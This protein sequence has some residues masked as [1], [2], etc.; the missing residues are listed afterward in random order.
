MYRNI[1]FLAVLY[2]LLFLVN[3]L[4]TGASIPSTVTNNSFK[5]VI[6]GTNN[7]PVEGAVVMNNNGIILAT[8]SNDG[9]FS[10]DLTDQS[11]ILI[12]AEGYNNKTVYPQEL[13]NP[14][15]E[16]SA[17][18]AS[19]KGR[20][21]LAFGS[22]TQNQ[23]VGAV[24]V[25]DA[26]EMLSLDNGQSVTDAIRGRVAGMY[27]SSNLRNYDGMVYLIDGLERDPS[28]LTIN[29]VD[30]I[31]VLKDAP[32]RML[33]GVKGSNGVVL[34]TTKR[35][36]AGKRLINVNAEYGI[37]KPVS[38][39]EFMNSYN[40]AK[41]FNEARV[42]DG[43]SPLYT[44][45]QLTGYQSGS[46]VQYPDEAY[47]NSTFL[48]NFTSQ[49]RFSAQFQG[50][51]ENT[52]YFLNLTGTTNN[53]LLNV[54]EGKKQ[55]N[56]NLSVRANVDTKITSFISLSVDLASYFGFANVAQGN[57]FGNAAT[58]R[59]NDYPMFI[60][61][62]IVPSVSSSLLT[63]AFITNGNIL[64]GNQT[65]QTNV[66]GDLMYGGYTK[67]VNRI[68]Q[69]NSHLVVDLGAV[70]KGLRFSGG[71]TFD[72][73][74]IQ[75]IQLSNTY[76]VYEPLFT[77]TTLTSI[78][79]YKIDQVSGSQGVKETA[80]KRRIGFFGNFEYANSF[81]NHSLYTNLIG[82]GENFNG[83]AVLQP[84][85][86]AH[87]GLRVNY[88]FKNRYLAEFD[89]A[90]TG[91][92]FLAP[93]NRFSFSPS[94]GIA[95]VLSNEGFLKGSK[96]IDLLKLRASWGIINTD[97]GFTT[98]HA[99]QNAY[100]NIS[101]AYA[102]GGLTGDYTIAALRYKS[103]ENTGLSF[104]KREDVNIGFE[105]S[106]FG[107]KLQLTGNWFYRKAY[108]DP[109]KLT[110]AYPDY[111]GGIYPLENAGE[112]RY[113]GMEADILFNQK[114]G[115]LSYSIGGNIV[116]QQGKVVIMDEP[117]YKYD[118]L[119]KVGKATDAIFGLVSE[120]L[121]KD[122]GEIASHAK[123][124]F[125]D[126]FPGDIKY[127]DLNNDG[128]IDQNDEQK[129]GNYNAGIYYG[130]NL[131]LG[132]KNLELFAIGSGQAGGDISLQDMNSNY[133]WVRGNQKYPA[134]LADVRWTPETSA[135]ATYPRLTTQ[136]SSNNFRT[137]SF[138]LRKNNWMRIH[139][140]Q[141]NF[142]FPKTIIRE[143]SKIKNLKLYVRGNNLLTASNIRKELDL[144]VGQAPQMRSY[145]IGLNANF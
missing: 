142:T 38:Y 76:S 84:V 113:H 35:G 137:S 29:E 88:G 39:P 37:A 36:E 63:S 136:E 31:V 92:R 46:R 124:S 93:E 117:F 34:I 141:L 72:L 128:I 50:G 18:S 125:G 143:G 87:Y 98:Y 103:I 95:W 25:L 108:D 97:E 132:Y 48:K 45:D 12:V 19:Q 2:V 64:G 71:L 56:D 60:P 13:K 47:Y 74:A 7:Q 5:A 3:N 17:L 123:Q 126:V 90:Y 32:S 122:A 104:G 134:Y 41:Y 77:G 4:L 54:G 43:L 10:A 116:Y 101:A 96:K 94:M 139:T 27:G 114:K 112:K 26:D 44:T 129:I 62:N 140:V 22:M 21:P 55:G 86:M 120:G 30:K 81:G 85:K 127:K 70:L 9:S 82:Y 15:I 14:S 100:E 105:S 61:T 138:W 83:D 91:S 11:E 130:L 115:D 40:Y 20:T 135:T 24:T 111:L 79:K 119:K 16:L 69:M 78:K 102:Y 49:G 68:N 1:K 23:M 65:Y 28:C 59:P 66:Y 118:Y 144:N 145:V 67:A 51:N 33:L 121:F 99:Y 52:R 109:A 53:S 58:F 6:T 42:N 110:N 8:T 73:S 131:K 80:F 107:N 75:T 89:G 57:F 133:Y 106:F